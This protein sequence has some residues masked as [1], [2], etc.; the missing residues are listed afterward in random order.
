VSRE[1]HERVEAE[2]KALRD[3]VDRKVTS[4]LAAE[5]MCRRLA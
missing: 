2:W 3:K 5:S 4:L 1:E